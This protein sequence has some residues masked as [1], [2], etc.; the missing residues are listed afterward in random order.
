[1]QLGKKKIRD[2]RL[3][4]GL[5]VQ[6]LAEARRPLQGA[7]SA[8][9]RTDRTSPSLA[10]LSEARAVTRHVRRLSGGRGGAGFLTWFGAAE[11]PRIYRVGATPRGWSCLS[12]QPKRNLE[13]VQAELPPGMSAGAKRISITAKRS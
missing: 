7:S 8:R 13:L 4:R 2:L 1:M 11:R 6:R 10:T 5:T 12:A 3:R 9:S